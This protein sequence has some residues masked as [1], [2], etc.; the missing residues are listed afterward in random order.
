MTGLRAGLDEAFRGLER[1][2]VPHKL[3]GIMRR[4]GS[5]VPSCGRRPWGL[6]LE[7]WVL[8]VAAY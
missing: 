7:E 2:E 4:R 8:L 3:V 5:G 1:A 6:P